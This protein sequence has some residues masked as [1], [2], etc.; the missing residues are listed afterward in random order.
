MVGGEGGREAVGEVVAEGKYFG[1][2]GFFL[3]AG[4][5]GSGSL[6]S[7]TVRPFHLWCS[8]P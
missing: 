6:T 5:V 1:E 3:W 4:G 7:F 2:V 8:K